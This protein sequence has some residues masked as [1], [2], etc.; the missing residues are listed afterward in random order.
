[1]PR[2]GL[3]TATAATAS[4][5]ASMP[6]SGLSTT[7]AAA[8]PQGQHTPQR[9]PTSTAAAAPPRPARPAEASPP[10]LRLPLSLKGAM[11]R[12]C[13]GLLPLKAEIQAIL[14]NRSRPG[15]QPRDLLTRKQGGLG[16]SLFDSPSG[17]RRVEDPA[18]FAV[19]SGTSQA[20][21]SCGNGINRKSPE[22]QS[23][24]AV[25]RAVPPTPAMG[26]FF[27]DFPAR[28]PYNIITHIHPKG[29]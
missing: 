12:L 18:A 26:A 28:I 7:T 10:Q 27:I 14:C 2:T 9:P 25:R 19:E 13:R 4:P 11:R 23:A 17:I 1:M 29:R 3:P 21:A 22:H 20:R 15:S 5:K 6:R 16:E 8:A 24:S